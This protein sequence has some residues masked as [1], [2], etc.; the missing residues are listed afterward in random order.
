[1]TDVKKLNALIEHYA[2]GSRS[3]FANLLA[4]PQ[5]TINTWLFRKAITA[6]GREQ[7]LDTFPELNRDW[8][9]HDATEMFTPHATAAVTGAHEDSIPYYSELT[10][11]CGVAEQFSLPEFASYHI[12]LPGVKALAAIPAE[13]DSM[14]PSIQDGDTVV[15]GNAVPL[16]QTSQQGI[17]LIIT[18]EGQRMF[19]RIQQLGVSQR[20]ILAVSDNPDYTPRAMLIEKSSI[21]S[22]FSVKCIIRN[23]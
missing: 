6:K 20:H 9:L 17:Y 5:S 22:V 8:L 16:S 10:G 7:I 19:K 23:M 15:I 11:T 3:K 2:E 21:L 13:G 12:S 14:Y 1:M 18:R 4:L